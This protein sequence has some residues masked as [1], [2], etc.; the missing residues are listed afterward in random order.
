MPG[1]LRIPTLFQ[2]LPTQASGAKFWTDQ[3]EQSNLTFFLH[4]FLVVLPPHFLSALLLSGIPILKEL[5]EF[6]Q[7]DVGNLY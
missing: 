4:D 6:L 3:T 5:Q 1:N 2:F 7:Y